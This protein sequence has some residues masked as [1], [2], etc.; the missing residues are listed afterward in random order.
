MFFFNMKMVFHFHPVCLWPFGITWFSLKKTIHHHQD[1][2][3]HPVQV[4]AA[5]ERPAAQKAT[6]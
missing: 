2:L 5:Q 1:F 4:Q 3:P 6:P